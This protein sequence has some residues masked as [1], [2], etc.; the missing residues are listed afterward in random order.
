MKINKKTL[1][2]SGIIVVAVAVVSTV[3]YFG[4]RY[5]VE[6]TPDYS[7]E[8]LQGATKSHSVELA[9]QYFD[10]DSV[11]NNLWPR[12]ET[13]LQ[14]SDN[15]SA[16]A[17]ALLDGQKDNYKNI[18]E[19]S[20]YDSIRSGQ[21]NN[22][23]SFMGQLGSV[24]NVKFAIVGN[25]ASFVTPFKNSNGT[26]NL[27]FVFTRQQN[28]T[29]K[30][31]DVQGFED[32]ISDGLATQGGNQSVQ[33]TSSTTTPKESL[34][35]TTAN[36]QTNSV[37]TPPAIINCS[38]DSQCG[39]S[40][41]T[42]SPSCQ[43]NAVY[44][45]YTTYTCNNPGT[46]Q[47]SCSNSITPQL[48]QTCSTS[49]TCNNGTCAAAATWHTASTYSDVQGATTSPFT[50][51]GSQL[52]ITYSCTVSDTSDTTSWFNG[53]IE[54]TDGSN[55]NVFANTVNC[56]GGDTTYV[57]QI[58]PGQYYLDLSNWNS[59]YTVTVEDYY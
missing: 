39:T 19:T 4:Y 34:N 9:D 45:N 5:Y 54:S 46:S 57:Y 25:T 32:V 48:Q 6:G 42:G 55:S 22:S 15:Y 29:W 37:N 10:S 27:S 30:I 24:K 3:S 26:Y 28:R 52:K 56:P 38:A 12:L 35:T 18:V 47:S 58:S 21:N 8:Q 53:V 51:Q 20:I 59:S 14:T 31:T 13:K 41:L 7:L 40:S 36:K 23:S 33:T 11:F 43:G 1:I 44:Q 17:V 16:L 2:I 50:V 49:Q